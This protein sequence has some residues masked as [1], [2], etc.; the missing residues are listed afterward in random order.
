MGLGLIPPILALV[1]LGIPPLLAG[2]YAGIANVDP[3]IVDA[4]RAMGMTEPQVLFRVEVPNALP[5]IVG[6]VRNATLQVIATATVAA[7]VNLGGLGRYI[8][9][10]L[11]LYRYDRVLV[12]A[13]LVA[14]LAL[15]VDGMLAVR[16]GRRCPGPAAAPHAPT[17]P[18]ASAR[19]ATLTPT[20]ALRTGDAMP[21]RRLRP[22][23]G[24][25]GFGD[26]RGDA[27]VQRAGDD[28]VRASSSATTD[29]IA[30][31]AA[32][33]MPSVIRRA[34]ASSA[35]LNT[36]GNASTLLIWFGKSLRPVAT[37]A[38][39]LRA[40]LGVDLRVRVRQREH[41]RLRRHRRDQLL[42]DLCP[43]TRPRN[44]SAPASASTAPPA[45]PARVGARGQLGLDL[46]QVGTRRGDDALRVEHHH[47]GDPRREQDVRARHAGGAGTGDHHLQS[48]D[49]AALHP[50]R[51]LERGQRHDRGAVLVVVHDRAVQRLDDPPL[52][53]E[54][55]R[56]R[57]VLEVH[58]AEARTQPDQGLDD[59]VGV[60]GVE[61]QRDRVQAGEV[62]EQRGLA[63][64]HRQRGARTDVAQAEH[65]R[66]RPI[67]RP[68]GGWSRCSGRP[69]SRPR[70][71]RGDTC[72][73]PGV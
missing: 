62:L 17:A 13:I 11:A 41:D 35:P 52:D 54:A 71:W 40:I 53:L 15:I 49:V 43:P 1:M 47:I 70:R 24:G 7:Y 68:P 58:G 34:P 48:G 19:P 51:T 5:L 23:R 69:G 31:A 10:G 73:T 20:G 72:A 33:F 50:G 30:S 21:T 14:V 55:A 42:R 27:R 65:R 12:G 6:G 16:C 64:H 61:H 32:S 59:L 4:A 38:A 3:P 46:V 66:C 37:I 39:C 57:D 36:P 25:D 26:G 60:L 45:T 56:R 9:D 29:R 8:F 63:L 67:R 18:P 28:L 22:G 44:T 2:A